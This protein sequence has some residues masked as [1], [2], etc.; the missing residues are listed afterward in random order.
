MELINKKH[1]NSFIAVV[2]FALLI[3]GISTALASYSLKS[4]IDAFFE[5]K[6]ITFSNIYLLSWLLFSAIRYSGGIVSSIYLIYLSKRTGRQLTW[7]LI[8]VFAAYASPQGYAL[9]DKRLFIPEKWFT[10]DYAAKREKCALPENIKFKTKPQLAVEM[11]T[12][13]RDEGILPFKYI[14]TDSLYGS[15]PEFINAVDR[16]PGV[17]YFVSMASDTRCW[18][19]RPVVR[20]KTYKYKGT[21][22]TRRILEDTSKTP[23]AFIDL[24]KSINDF[25]WYRRKVSEG[26]KGPIMYE[27]GYFLM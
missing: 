23:I 11:F 5:Q 9:I 17:T 8:G 18:L 21:V 22:K 3:G 6:G 13:I 20:E 16:L 15:S 26:T 27:Q 2:S 7:G 19:K 4:A 1:F 25:F 14:A 24:A 12:A 10:K